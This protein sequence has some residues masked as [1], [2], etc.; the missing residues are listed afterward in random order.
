MRDTI[1]LTI[2]LSDFQEC[3]RRA[4]FVGDMLPKLARCSGGG[5]LAVNLSGHAG[6]I[7]GILRSM[8][9]SLVLPEIAVPMWDEAA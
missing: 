3:L 4:E 7:I 2:K 5:D 1:T 6:H 8:E 9:R